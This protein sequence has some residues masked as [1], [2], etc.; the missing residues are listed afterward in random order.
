[1]DQGIDPR[2]L[3]R[4]QEEQ[5]AAK[6]AAKEAAK[7]EAESRKRY[8]LKAL[9]LAYLAHLEAQGK[10]KSAAATKSAFK[11]H[12]FVPHPAIADTCAADVTAH[13]IAAIV[14]Q[15]KE[16]GKER[17]AGILRSYLSAAFNAAKKS[18]FDANLPAAMIP[19]N[20]AVNPVEPVATIPVSAGN[21]T[22]TEEELKAYLAALG[23]D[24]TDQALKLAL[25]A[26]GQRMAQLIRAKVNDYDT[27]TQTLRLQDIKG[28]RSTPREHL[29]PLAPK[30]AALVSALVERSSVKGSDLLFSSRKGAMNF[31][32]PGKRAK[33]ISVLMGGEPFDLRDIRRT[34]E[35]ML[36]GMGVTRD[37]RA[38]LLSHGISGVQD[39]HYDR[40]SYTT[41]K[42]GALIRWERQLESIATGKIADKIVQIGNK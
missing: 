6:I 26:G 27:K 3:D 40:H 16:S 23:D 5:K 32:T 28:K 7:V 19:F 13:H 8:T 2:E 11:C 4:E 14:R 20:V 33:E 25:F 39:V 1:L 22:L 31:A 34:C 10:V 12:V 15:V 18:P 29:L 21:R 9:C 41:E 24:L 37:I 17:M 30:A 35:T 38:Q 36:A 42:R